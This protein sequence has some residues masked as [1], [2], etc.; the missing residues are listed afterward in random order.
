MFERFDAD[1]RSVVVFSQAEAREFCADHIGPEHLLLAA[2]RLSGGVA[3]AAF[4]G[5]GIDEAGVRAAV[6]ALV[7]ADGPAPGGH[8]PFS[9]AAKVALESSLRTA[10][11]MGE[12]FI[13][14]EHIVLGV[15][16]AQDDVT[17]R[18]LSALKVDVP[19]LRERLGWR[20][21]PFPEGAGTG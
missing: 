4:A 15:T 5:C 8:I 1:A 20:D 11:A 13:G 2:T 7:G 16:F 12:N 18:V 10:L 9:T 6:R 19:A 14:A 3:A 21:Q 17:A